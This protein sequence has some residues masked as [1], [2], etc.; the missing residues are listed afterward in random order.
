[1]NSEKWK[2]KMKNLKW[3]REIERFVAV[4][5][6]FV[7]WGNIYDIYPKNINGVVQPL[8]LNSYLKHLLHYDCGYD[9][10]VAYEPLIGF[11]LL[12]GREEDFRLATN[13]DISY[14]KPLQSTLANAVEIM[15]QIVESKS[16]SIALIVNYSS[17]LNDVI[18]DR[19]LREF[20]YISFRIMQS[21]S[22]KLGRDRDIKKLKF[23]S[24]F[25]LI[26]KESDLPDWYSIDNPHIKILSLPKPDSMVRELIITQSS[27]HIKG[28]GE[29]DSSK[30]RE[31]INHFIDQTNG[32]YANEIVSI[33]SLARKEEIEF[34]QINEAI[35]RY[36]LGIIENEWAKIPKSKLLNAKKLLAERVK[37]QE[38]SIV[39]ASE[40]IKRAYF[41][42][43]GT[44]YSKYSNRPKGVLFFA[45]PTGVGKTELAK[46]ITNLLFGSETSYIRF[47]MSEFSKDH[48]DQ[49]LIGAPPGYVGYDMGGELTNAIKQNPFSVV[50]FDEIE[51]AHPKIMDIFLQILDDGRI[52]SGRGET[53]YFSE[54]LI[55]FTSNLG[56]YEIDAEGQRV[57]NDNSSMSYEV[58][59]ANILQSI[60]THFK[61]KLQ[62]PEILNR[63]GENIV[64]F[65]FIRES[66]AVEIFEKMLQS[67]IDALQESHKIE[68]N[69]EQIRATLLEEST[70]DLSMGGRG[71]GNWLEKIFINPLSTALV[72]RENSN[73]EIEVINLR[74][75]NELW[76][77]ELI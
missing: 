48:S 7:L 53:V 28:F 2:I 38:R 3:A 77:L 1:M 25:W 58:I 32:L 47:D 44:Q 75:E 61:F 68:L 69:I 74:K 39:K 19:E 35:K 52:T 31:N 16:F 22:P 66:V 55:I 76:I 46:S 15:E 30:K 21:A 18:P 73:R 6:Q 51:K 9:V 64:V 41:N 37:G 29:L 13:R 45:G 67:V 24:I 56:I 49:R 34:A 11:I 20:F 27:T 4:K 10:V 12:E 5:P 8:S 63:I 26:D 40:V 57:E 42:L 59:R 23:N 65:D 36:K 43:S 54:A 71:I 72:E 14:K 33:I 17:R 60:N 70:R 50:L 62:R